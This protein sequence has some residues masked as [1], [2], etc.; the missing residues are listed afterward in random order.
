[1]GDILGFVGQIAGSAIQAG[2]SKDVTQMQLDAIKRQQQLV[3]NSLDPSVIGPQAT[4]ADVQRAQQQLA[5]QGQIDPALLQTRYTAEGG[6]KNQLDQILASN[7]P[8]DQVAKLAASTALTPTP[9]LNDVKNKLVDAA[10]SDLKAGATLPP[11]IEA[12]IVQHGLEQSGMVTGKATAQ[13][14]GG[15][16][17]RT[18]FGTEGLKLQAQREAQ[19]SGLATSA[20]QLDTARSQ[21]LGALFPNLTAQ[22]TSK[23]AATGSTF[24]ATQ[25]AVPQAGLSGTDIANI[26]M[27]RVGATN[28]L[29][30]SAAN[31]ASQGAQAQSAIWG[32]ALGGAT[33][34]APGVYSNLQNLFSN[35]QPSAATRS[36]VDASIAAGPVDTGGVSND[37]GGEL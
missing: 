23:L 8:A 7:A 30:Q 13:G 5:L 37:F 6:L 17:L 26:W 2:A 24:G 4:S 9:G 22:Q 25:A 19:A 21:V 33:R 28:A 1:V 27:A 16:M 20:Q 32:N 31:A 35:P 34:A 3:Y 18:L 15:T 14:V 12:Q 10:L 29:T 11:D 36:A